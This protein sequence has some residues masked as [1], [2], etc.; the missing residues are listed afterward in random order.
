MPIPNPKSKPFPIFKLITILI[1]LFRFASAHTIPAPLDSLIL[2][3]KEHIYRL[4][5]NQARDKFLQS[6]EAYPDY[7]HGYIYQAYITALFYSLDQTNDSL[8]LQLEEQLKQAIDI[9]KDYKN[10]YNDSAGS[11]FHLALANSIKALY[12]VVDRSYVK[13]YWYGRKAK[14]D[15]NKVMELDSAYYDAYLGLGMFHYYA[16]LLPG[17]LKFIAGILGFDGD[18]IKG[19]AEINLTAHKGHYFK[20]ESEFLYHS[21][22]YFLEGDKANAFRALQ[23]LYEKYPGNQGLG[24]MIAYH[25]RRTG[26]IDQCIDICQ[27]LIR[28]K[29]P[30][31]LPQITNFKYYNLAVCYYDLNEFDKADS[32]LT[33][34]DQHP[35]RKSLYYQAAVNYYRGHLADLRFERDSALVYYQKIPRHKQTLYWYWLSRPLLKYPTDSLVYQYFIAANLLGSRRFEESMR[36]SLDL[37]KKL[38]N[39]KS[40]SNP[41]TRFLAGD[42][43]GRNYFYVRKYDQSKKAFEEIAP[44]LGKMEDEMRRAW[45]YIHYHYLL[46]EMGDY[47]QAGEMLKKADNIDD[48]YTRIIVER[49]KFILKTKYKAQEELKD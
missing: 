17:F 7:P 15:L 2:K 32:V 9:A 34:L 27:K 23:K 45:I 26:Y 3:G 36:L 33:V 42:I 30:T 39:S 49:E 19:K 38:D 28:E 11:Y 18:R 35:V 29:D 16:D 8:A 41:D 5:F 14:N 6:Q 22:G 20:V 24:V 46:R 40:I 13:G 25:Y 44:D 47:K 48:D 37:K 4:E 10:R 21:I 12:Y 1:L 31:M 43:L